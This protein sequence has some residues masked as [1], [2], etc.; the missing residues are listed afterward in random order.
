MHKSVIRTVKTQNTTFKKQFGFGFWTS[1]T[2]Q[3]CIEFIEVNHGSK[4]I[5]V[6]QLISRV[7]SRLL[8]G[9]RQLSFKF[10]NPSYYCIM[11]AT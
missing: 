10:E 3:L 2:G 11:E 7:L 6:D 5:K 9:T 8:F 1:A 4:G